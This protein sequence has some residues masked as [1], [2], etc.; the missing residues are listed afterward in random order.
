M[1]KLME[2]AGI[3]AAL[4]CFQ[5]L[6]ACGFEGGDT[7]LY[8]F[9]DNAPTDGRDPTGLSEESY[10]LNWHHMLPREY[11]DATKYPAA[12]VI[13]RE[14]ELPESFNVH[15]AR[16]GYVVHEVNHQG[17]IHAADWNQ[18]WKDWIKDQIRGIKEGRRDPVTEYELLD[19]MHRMRNSPKYAPFFDQQKYPHQLNPQQLREQGYTTYQEWAKNHPGTPQEAYDGAYA[20][21]KQD[22]QEIRERGKSGGFKFGDLTDE[23]IDELAKQEA[24]KA[25]KNFISK[26]EQ[27]RAKAQATRA[28]SKQLA[29]GQPEQGPL[30]DNK[31]KNRKIAD[32]AMKATAILAILKGTQTLSGVAF[33]D[34][35]NDRY[36][37]QLQEVVDA[38][39]RA[40]NQTDQLQRRADLIALNEKLHA[41]LLAAGNEQM[42]NDLSR[43]GINMKILGMDLPDL[44][45]VSSTGVQPVP[46]VKF[47][48]EDNPKYRRRAVEL[49]K[50]QLTYGASTQL[51]AIGDWTGGGWLYPTY[52]TLMANI[53]GGEIKLYLTGALLPAGQYTVRVRVDASILIRSATGDASALVRDSAGEQRFYVWG[54]TK[55]GDVRE[56]K[57]LTINVTHAGGVSKSLVLTFT[58]QASTFTK[59]GRVSVVENVRVLSIEGPKQ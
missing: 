59:N 4:S 24:E 31:A 20:K 17:G 6:E 26:Q 50:A 32:N 8:R 47:E 28:R 45:N 36:A 13:L 30:F 27:K 12:R 43:H 15:E 40:R 35:N 42:A 5:C 18:D 10:A 23:R 39:H 25:Q 3:D 33:G 49:Q 16:W 1:K 22:W 41:L 51:T 19:E 11:F 38:Y 48:I 53:G 54:D 52:G 34:M 2:R 21:A 46:Q 58:P 57:D 29:Q 55:T 37:A 44:S 56:E 7:N 14:L 9:V